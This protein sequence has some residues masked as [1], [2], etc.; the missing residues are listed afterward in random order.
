MWAI[1]IPMRPLAL[2]H[3]YLDESLWYWSF[4][5]PTRFHIT[6]GVGYPNPDETSGIRS[7]E[8]QWYLWYWSFRIPTGFHITAQGCG[9]TATLG[10]R[11]PS[12]CSTPKGVASFFMAYVDD[13]KNLKIPIWGNIFCVIMIS[14][15]LGIWS[16][17]DLKHMYVIVSNITW[18][19][20]LWTHW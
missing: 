13:I 11:S 1:L 15:L 10:T 9:F 17:L 14:T 12:P 18:M 16:F 8:F 19:E 20:R 6:S 7:F 2:G 3:S 4:R 5:I